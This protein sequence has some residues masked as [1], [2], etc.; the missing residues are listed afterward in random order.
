MTTLG[1]LMIGI[2]VGRFLEMMRPGLW[3]ANVITIAV[4]L[5]LVIVGWNRAE[6]RRENSAR[7]SRQ[8]RLG[9]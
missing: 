9:Q 8:N 5:V 1:L 2:S 7:N 4:G 6:N 3:V